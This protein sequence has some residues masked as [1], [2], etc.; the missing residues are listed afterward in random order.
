M[1]Q[2]VVLCRNGLTLFQTITGIYYPRKEA[3]SKESTHP[4]VLSCINMVSGLSF[5]VLTVGRVQNGR[6][7]K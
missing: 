2:N 1:R 5:F 7:T 6:R 3:E 4:L